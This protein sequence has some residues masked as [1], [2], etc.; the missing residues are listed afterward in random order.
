MLF[1]NFHFQA[2][3]TKRRLWLRI[4]AGFRTSAHVKPT[5]TTNET[6]ESVSQ[7]YQEL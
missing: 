1:R 5:G 2:T 6:S 3:A 7:V 4:E